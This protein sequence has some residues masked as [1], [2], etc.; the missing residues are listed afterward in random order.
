AQIYDSNGNIDPERCAEICPDAHVMTFHAPSIS[1]SKENKVRGYL[2]H[3]FVSGGP[4]HTWTASEVNDKVQGTSSA[5]YVLAGLNHDFEIVSGI[6]LEDETVIDKYAMTPNSIPVNYFNF[7]LNV[8]S[9]ENVNNIVLSEWYNRFQ[10]YKR[11][12]RLADPRIRDCIEGHMALLFYHNTGSAP[13]QAGA[14]IVQPN[15]TILY[16]IGTLNNSKK[17]LEVFGQTDEWD[18]DMIVIETLNN[19]SD[20]ARFKSDDLTGETWD[21]NGNYE[22]R[23]LSETMTKAEAAALWQQ[24]LSFVVSCD[25]EQATNRALSEPATYG[26]ETYNLDTRAYR[27]AK[28]KAE[29][30]NYFVLDS[31]DYHYLFTLVLCLPDNRAKNTFWGWSKQLRKW[32]LVFSYDHDT[33]MGN[34]NEGGLTLRYGYLDTD[35]IGT[36]AVFNA[37]DSALWA[38]IREAFSTELRDMFIE[39][40]NAGCWNFDEIAAI[41]D[42]EQRKI[43]PALWAEDSKKKY[44]DP[45]V[46]NGSTAY[47]PMLNGKK[48]LQRAQFLK[49]QRQFMSSFFISNYCTSNTGT[50]R[51]YTPTTW[52]GVRPESKMTITPYCDMFVTV[53]A[54]SITTQQRAYAGQ[55]VE[56]NLSVPS[57]ND[58]EIYP[59]NAQFIQDIG[60][61]ACLYPGYCDLAPFTRLK[62]A[63]IGSSV[64]GYTN[65]NLTEVSV[66]NCE[67][68]EYLN[69]ENCPELKQALSLSNNIMLKQLYT[70]GSGVTGVTFAAG[71]RVQ[72]AYLNDIV[73]LTA[74]SLYYLTNLSFE[75]YNNLRTLIVEESPAINSLLIIQAAPN[76]AYVRLL[77]V[78]WTMV[79]SEPLVD[80]AD[81]GGVDDDGYNTGKAVLTG[82]A[83]VDSISAGRLNELATTF[84]GLTIVYGDLLPEHT[85]TFMADENTV[86]DVQTV[87]HGGRARTPSTNPPTQLTAEKV[88]T[89][90]GWSGAFN[91][92]LQDT[93][94]SAVYTE[95]TRQYTVRFLN[96]LSVVQTSV[97]DVHSG[98][99]YTGPDL[100]KNGYLWTG[101]D[102][103]T[104]DVI[105]DMDVNA[106]FEAPALPQAV[107]DMTQYD[108]LYS[109][110]PNDSSAY[111]IGELYAICAAGLAST[112]MSVGDKL[113]IT[114]TE[115]KTVNDDYILFQLYGFN[116]FKLEDGSAFANAV[117]G[118]K[119]VLISQRRMNP[120]NTN[121][122]GW[123][124]SEM[125]TWLN[126]TMLYNLPTVWR[127]VI[128]SVQVLSSAGKQSA[129]I[130]TSIDKLFLFSWSELG[131]DTN[132]VPYRDE[133]DAG[134]ERKTF[135]IFTD[136]A[137][138][139]KKTFN[140]EGSASNWWLRSPVAASSTSFG[141]VITSGGSGNNG[142]SV[143]YGV[144]FGFC[145]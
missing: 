107:A 120:T 98:C 13:V 37:A 15:E 126:G 11:P 91:N 45:F 100:V 18:D 23:Y 66:T 55:P 31:L 3:K 90:A 6:T 19:T 39:L 103:V 124:D 53:K 93:V 111:T 139:I 138:R 105:A 96:G 92:I 130:L 17:N 143:A 145:I 27:L 2:T 12:A 110:N 89:F 144:A 121:E 25:P 108:Y 50:I 63:C 123:R 133:I 56:L 74:K 136:N 119:G 65:T 115:G 1:T 112:Y 73:S 47:L 29:A 34:D 87:E 118:M 129:N 30:G 38:L 8:A 26:D 14:T 102:A 141:I 106:V 95:T 82:T 88:L 35:V 9:S 140:G 127:N 135:A 10:K 7:K 69:V 134:A 58:T 122:G 117:F 61:L 84:P 94:V 114:L 75:E 33:G 4:E 80:I 16:G 104:K 57:M 116:H 51:G 64:E 22:F 48:R 109:D 101:W 72:T 54:G 5:A 46:N 79:N 142:A 83:Y 70:R 60:E 36:K 128:K 44:I 85:V 52:E 40:E 20:Q 43:C 76:I 113:K 49:F 77:E 125:R 32:H 68:L 71:A 81:L 59:Y 62:R 21:K 24:A 28:F 137:S 99:D 97:V 86:W 41:C 132:A 78:D 131:W 67:A 42:A